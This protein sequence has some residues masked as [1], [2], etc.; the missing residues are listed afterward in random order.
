MRSKKAAGDSKMPPST[1]SQE[2][3]K[4]MRGCAL[5]RIPHKIRKESIPQFDNI[6]SQLLLQRHT[7]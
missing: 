7:F 2:K 5:P 4:M 1:T 6:F 3:S